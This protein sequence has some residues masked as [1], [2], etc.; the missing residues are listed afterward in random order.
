MKI[1][2]MNN[3]YYPNMMGGAEHSIKLLAEQLA[4]TGNEV[5][6]LSMDGAEKADAVQAE[7]INGVFVHRSYCKSI[8]R[9]RILNDKGYMTDKLLNGWYSVHNGKMNRSEEHTS[10]LQSH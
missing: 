7:E 6:I 3:Y 4:R 8:Y 2:I 5:H 10:E 9:R 1:L